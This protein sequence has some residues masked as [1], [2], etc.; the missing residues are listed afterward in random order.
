MLIWLCAI[1]GQSVERSAGGKIQLPPARLATDAEIDR[2]VLPSI[3]VSRLGGAVSRDTDA[4]PICAHPQLGSEGSIID[5][6]PVRCDASLISFA[7]VLEGLAVA[8]FSA[9]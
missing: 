4:S 7:G 9:K 3:S 2:A 8:A 5:R 6:P 1:F